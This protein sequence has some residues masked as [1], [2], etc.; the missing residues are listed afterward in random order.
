MSDSAIVRIPRSSANDNYA[1]VVKLHVKSGQAVKSGD[2]L[3]EIESTK[4][5][6][7]IHAP[8]SGPIQLLCQEG[9]R[10]A[11]GSSMAHIGNPPAETPQTVHGG[12]CTLK[13]HKLMSQNN[14]NAEVFA[15]LS[16]VRV[17]HVQNFIAD[18]LHFPLAE[19][20]TK[21]LEVEKIVGNSALPYQSS[22]SILVQVEG[23]N[24]HIVKCGLLIS[25]PDLL[26]FHASRILKSFPRLNG[27]YQQGPRSYRHV[28]LGVTLN[29]LDLGLKVVTLYHADKLSLEQVGAQVKELQLRY[30]RKELSPQELS[31]AT[32]TLTSLYHLDVQHFIPLLPQRQAAIL[33]VGAPQ[34]SGAIELTL[35]FDHRQTDGL[36]AA[37]FLR[38]LRQASAGT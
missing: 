23:L 10:L 13:A 15:H 26:L 3:A 33:G 16:R 29:M 24:E 19:S 6:I 37:E 5:Q 18:Q 22:V 30:V 11:V 28:N 34:E 38:A 36:E 27:F 1:L 7:E 2:L 25:V 20:N 32:F 35:S 14:I 4:T 9:D 12:H 8:V 21:K 17:E 31:G